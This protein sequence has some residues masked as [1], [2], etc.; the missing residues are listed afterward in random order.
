[1]INKT[2]LKK[3]ASSSPLTRNLLVNFSKKVTF[4]RHP[5]E[6][7]YDARKTLFD[8]IVVNNCICQLSTANY[9]EAVAEIYYYLTKEKTA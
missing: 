5:H 1:M 6:Y 7:L 9:Q 8:R 2:K 4:A 3:L